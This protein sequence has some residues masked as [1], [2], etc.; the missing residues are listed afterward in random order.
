MVAIINTVLIDTHCHINDPKAFPDPAATLKEAKEAGVDRVIV[1]GVNEPSIERAIELADQFDEVDAVVGL[2]PNYAQ[3]RTDALMTRIVELMRH[4]KV[5]ALGEIG[6]D[7]HWDFAT[8][9]Q[10]YRSLK[11]QLTLAREADKPVVFHCRE[12]YPDL[13]AILEREPLHPYLIHCFAGDPKDAACA[14]DLGCLFGVDGPL[15][16]K[17]AGAFRD[18][19]AG[20]P[21]DRVV[22]ETDSPYMTPV[23]HRGQ[24]NK[25]AY[26]QLVCQTLADVWGISEEETAAITTANAIRFFGL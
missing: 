9:E 20:L 17:S 11:E 5:R 15:T 13:L 23:P 3:E 1:V 18:L 19:V 12:A 16:Y 21:H 8:P 10:Q 22:L 24:P 25:P 4:P 7:Y 14:L 6:L 26:V 2:H